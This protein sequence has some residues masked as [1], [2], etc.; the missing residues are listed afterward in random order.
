MSRS[1]RSTFKTMRRAGELRFEPALLKEFVVDPAGTQT[2]RG[3]YCK[4]ARHWNKPTM[5]T[6]EP[7]IGIHRDVG[8]ISFGMITS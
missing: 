7:G 8:W 1:R 3:E 5:M 4:A 6:K 2:Q